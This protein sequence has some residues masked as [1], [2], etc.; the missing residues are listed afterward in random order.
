MKDN[1]L[2]KVKFYEKDQENPIEI[3]V[4]IVEPSEFPGLVCFADF[5][6]RDQTKKIIMPDEDKATKRFKKTRSLHIPYHNIL[7]IE[8]IEEEE[9]DLKQLPFLREIA[10]E[11]ETTD[12]APIQ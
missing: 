4:R 3:L 5:V 7:F 9:V 10:T 6:F 8:E 12:P 1:I 11:V 2:F